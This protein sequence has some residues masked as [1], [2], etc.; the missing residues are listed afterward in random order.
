MGRPAGTGIPAADR[1]WP[2]VEKQGGDG[3]W[4]WTAGKARGYGRFCVGV[5]KVVQ[6]HAWSYEQAR[7]PVPKGKVLDH[8]CE[9]K[10]CVR[11]DHCVPM[12]IGQNVAWHFVQQTHCT[13]GHSLADALEH[14]GRRECRTCNRDRCRVRR[15]QK[16]LQKA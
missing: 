8:T 9:Q 1:F 5:G 3:C 6:A 2:K 7:G 12:T 13:N 16:E 14:H 10:S 4:L 11:P 15:Q